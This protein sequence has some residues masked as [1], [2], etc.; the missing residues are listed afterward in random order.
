MKMLKVRAALEEKLKQ[1]GVFGSITPKTNK[2]LK[3]MKPL[4]R[5]CF[6][7]L[8]FGLWFLH[9]VSANS[10]NLEMNRELETYDDFDDD[11]VNVEGATHGLNNGH[12]SS[13]SSSK[14]SHLV[15]AN[16]NKIKVI[17]TLF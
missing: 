17:S 9:I 15:A 11:A 8:L 5:Y 13:L 10:A 14:L 1:K 4:N 2:A 3:L 12:K 6:P 7:P 16:P